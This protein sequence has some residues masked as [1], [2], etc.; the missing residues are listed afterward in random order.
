VHHEPP[1][2]LESIM[3]RL[4]SK[5]VGLLLLTVSA[6]AQEGHKG[7]A[8][9]G[10]KGP[11]V[12]AAAAQT[13]TGE[14]MDLACY[15][16]HPESGQGAEHAACAAQCINKGLPAGLK[17]GTKLYLLVGKGHDSI[18]D[19]LAPLAGKQAKITGHLLEKE[20]L[21]AIIVHEVAAATP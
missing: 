4:V 14:V 5:L 17:V 21:P 19:K 15:L 13:F 12:V 6:Q 11:E 8:G 16:Q 3:Y 2:D 1:I 20:G 7:H 18:A 9:H 10:H